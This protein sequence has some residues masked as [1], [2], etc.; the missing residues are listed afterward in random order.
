MEVVILPC[1][2]DRMV[3]HALMELMSTVVVVLLNMEAN[4]VKLNRW[5]WVNKC[6]HKHH[7]VN[8]MIASMVYA[9]LLQEVMGTSANAHPGIQVNKSSYIILK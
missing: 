3:V 2:F 7:H 4:F 5:C 8:T 9:L 6:T 1:I